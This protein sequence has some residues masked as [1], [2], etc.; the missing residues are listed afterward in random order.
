MKQLAFALLPRGSWYTDRPSFRSRFENAAKYP[1][2][3]IV[4]DSTLIFTR[5]NN[6][7][8]SLPFYLLSTC[9]LYSYLSLL[10]HN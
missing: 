5:G 7:A 6:K 9:W 2:S 4:A 3:I 8:S 1:A 10:I